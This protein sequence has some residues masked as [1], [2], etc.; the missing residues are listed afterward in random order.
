MKKKYFLISIHREENVDDK[1]NFKK[2]LEALEA[3]ADKYKLPI[4]VSTHPRTKKKA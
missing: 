2:L 3:I 1:S 4:I